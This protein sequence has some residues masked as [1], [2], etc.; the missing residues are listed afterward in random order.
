M[1]IRKGDQVEVISGKDRGKRG[2][3]LRL[4]RGSQRAIVEGVNLV[5]KHAKQNP[6]M[7]VQGGIIEQEAPVHLSN[8]LPIDPQTNQPTRVG[9]K[10][11]TRADG[12][13]HKVRVSRR[14]GAELDR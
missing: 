7:G 5:K 9:Y 14:S 10:F 6:R 12:K 2:K 13:P 1:R 4:F 3:V 11:L 8:L